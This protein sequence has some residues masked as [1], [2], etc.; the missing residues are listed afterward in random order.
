MRVRACPP[1]PARTRVFFIGAGP[2]DPGLLTVRGAELLAGCRT[3]FAPRPY[4][5]TFASLL[6]G[7]EVLVPFDFP[8]EPLLEVIESRLREGDVAVLVPGDLTFFSPFQAL[9]DLLGDRAEVLPG[10]G[11]ASAAAARLKRT[12]NH[13]TVC[14]RAVIASPR[15]LA[16]EK[17][18]P[19]LRDLAAPGTTLLL[20]MNHLPLTELAAELRAGYGRNVPI[21]LFHRLGLPG[22]AVVTG[23]LD[24]I[25]EKGAGHDFF[26]P[27]RGGRS[28]L[29]LVVAGEALTAA[30]SGAWWDQRWQEVWRFQREQ[31]GGG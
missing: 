16:E 9:I 28:A 25:A 21:A 29:T 23:T 30:S 19:S 13:A 2:G 22:E 26:T 27:D 20:Y 4:E 1:K 12:L 31:M 3:V 10:V 8:F 15:V 24:D 18:A 5:V 17:G 11:S 6:A 14:T 7:K